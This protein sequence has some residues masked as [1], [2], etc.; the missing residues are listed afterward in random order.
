MAKFFWKGLDKDTQLCGLLSLCGNY[1]NSSYSRKEAT[2]HRQIGVAVSIKLYLQKQTGGSVQFSSVQ[3]SCSVVSDSLRPHGLYHARPPY[4]SPTPG[5]YS[6][7]LLKLI[8][9]VM[10]FNY[11]ILC[12][13]LLLLPSIF[14]SIRLF[15]YESVADG[16]SSTS[17]V[18]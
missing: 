17:E 9:S 6:N 13:P 12:C 14:P 18:I 3:F 8:E 2:D 1:P 4:P 5:D 15:S 7:S 11:L 16:E 10:P